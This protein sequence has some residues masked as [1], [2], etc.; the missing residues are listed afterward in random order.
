M[1]TATR[2]MQ[3]GERVIFRNHD[4][5]PEAAL[6]SGTRWSID[7]K[8]AIDGGQVHRIESDDELHLSVFPPSGGVEAR[9]NVP[10]GNGPGQWSPADGSG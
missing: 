4:G 3:L 2:R 8:R 6:V 5:L 10:Q 7:P 9:Q 1:T